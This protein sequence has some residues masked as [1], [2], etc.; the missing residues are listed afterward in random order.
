[1]DTLMVF[2]F[3]RGIKQQA[4]EAKRILHNTYGDGLTPA[5]ICPKWYR[6]TRSCDLNVSKRPRSRCTVET[7]DGDF[8]VLLVGN[9]AARSEFAQALDL[10]RMMVD[11]PLYNW[12]DSKLVGV[13]PSLQIREE[14]VIICKQLLSQQRRKRFLP[15]TIT[16]D[17]K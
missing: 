16:S 1:M 5:S 15:Q 9:S 10:R 11:L 2:L 12:Y 8:H 13:I 17:E 4:T 6:Y 7:E 3:K 14:R